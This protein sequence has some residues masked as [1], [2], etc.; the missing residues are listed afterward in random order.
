MAQK[1][2][3]SY[4]LSEYI[5]KELIW[6]KKEIHYLKSI[7]RNKQYSAESRVLC[8]SVV[9]M[10]YSHWEGFV[11][12][13]SIA[14]LK[15]IRNCSLPI[16]RLSTDIIAS[17]LLNISNNNKLHHIAQLKKILDDPNSTIDFN[18]NSMINTES[19]LNSAVLEKILCSLGIKSDVFNLKKQFIDKTIL[20]NRNAYA[21]GDNDYINY[22][23]C[24]DIA[25]TVIELLDAYK[26]ILDNALV[27]KVHLKSY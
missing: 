20:G 23:D 16:S 27:Q 15:Y 18:I 22:N 25:E 1:F 11:K 10:S 8:K 4:E 12:N 9:V 24:I 26:N 7:L 21:H 17:L 3:S 14:Y 13:V 5:D 2:R 6:R 19:N